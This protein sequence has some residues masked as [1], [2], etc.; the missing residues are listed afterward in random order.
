MIIMEIITTF[1]YVKCWQLHFIDTSDNQNQLKT[2]VFKSYSIH[3]LGAKNLFQIVLHTTFS[4]H[5]WIEM[6]HNARSM[7]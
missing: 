5:A 1:V 3:F 6:T 4:S 7:L 2:L